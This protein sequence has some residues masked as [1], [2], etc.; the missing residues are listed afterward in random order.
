MK[1]EIQN[2]IQTAAAEDLPE[3]LLAVLD[4]YA[5]LFPAW[6]LS[7]LSVEKQQDRNAQ[8]DGVIAVLNQLKY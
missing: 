5:V 4:R 6:E 3:I 7:V 1:I 2:L 8:I